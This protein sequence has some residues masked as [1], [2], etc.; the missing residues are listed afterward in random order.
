[1]KE[2]HPHLTMDDVTMFISTYDYNPT[3]LQFMFR[4]AENDS[5]YSKRLY[6]ARQSEERKKKKAATAEQKAKDKEEQERATLAKLKA[7]YEGET[8]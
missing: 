8:E 5:E 2:A 1:V 7:K 3:E 4:R 6:Y